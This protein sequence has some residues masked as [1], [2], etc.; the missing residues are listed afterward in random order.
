MSEWKGKGKELRSKSRGKQV[1]VL[2][3]SRCPGTSKKVKQPAVAL[4]LLLLQ[5]LLLHWADVT[6]VAIVATD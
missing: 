1:A 5:L 2:F 3:M 6:Q 4:D